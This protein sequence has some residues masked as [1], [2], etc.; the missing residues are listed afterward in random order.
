MKKIFC[1]LFVLVL[2]LS[3]CS[4]E[5]PSTAPS[6][7]VN[8]IDNAIYE[9]CF[10]KVKALSEERKGLVSSEPLLEYDPDR[11]VYISFANQ[12][13]DFYPDYSW[14]KCTALVITKDAI[15]PNQIQVNI[16]IQTEYSVEVTDWRDT[17]LVPV[18]DSEQPS[19][20]LKL[21]QYMSLQGVDLK[22]IAQMQLEADLALQMMNQCDESERLAYV[23]I[24][25][26]NAKKIGEI[27]STWEES[28]NKISSG[29]I[30][31]FGVYLVVI[32]FLYE[33]E[34]GRYENT[35]GSFEE[36]VHNLTFTI[37]GKSYE[38]DIGTW[39]FHKELPQELSDSRDGSGNLVGLTKK[40]I[41]RSALPGSP[42]TNGIINLE[43]TFHFIA[44]ED[45][46]ITGYRVV[47]SQIDVLGAQVQVGKKAPYFWNMERPIEVAAGEEVIIDI[48]V[49]DERFTKHDVYI[50]TTLMLDYKIRDQEYHFG[51][52]NG[53]IRLDTGVWDTYLMAF[54]GV[55]VSTYLSYQEL[56][57]SDWLQELPESWY[58][59]E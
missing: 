36:T 25:S 5:S 7:N 10:Q 6:T 44:E 20:A 37:A 4:Q 55:D 57:Q 17:V 54:H 8:G 19:R 31:Q 30:P 49:Y 3:G 48:Y 59:Q 40:F 18:H 50:N 28:F 56:Y 33:K 38:V 52:P 29:D 34:P 53:L 26:D 39:R 16:P 47:G 27:Y 13:C 12:E 2:L 51:V 41:Q 24:A 32:N 43:K 14:W 58:K 15:D 45:L 23:K 21:D 9:S 22:E 35:I 42:Y 46:T 11:E 1:F